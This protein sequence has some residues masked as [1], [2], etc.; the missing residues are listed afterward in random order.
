MTGT[1]IFILFLLNILLVFAV[2]LLYMRQNRLVE[3]EQRQQQLLEESEHA[4]A[5]LLEEIKDE[6]ENLIRR[7]Y[8][9]ND[10]L[11]STEQQGDERKSETGSV[12]EPEAE[13][14]P[15]QPPENIE[16]PFVEVVLSGDKEKP[17][18]IPLRDQVE[19]LAKEG[20]SIS[21]IAKK[22]RKGKTEIELLM[23]LQ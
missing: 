16:T 12:V 22:L 21:E 7:L 18:E 20:W 8:G 17:E 11:A 15:L 2:V 5:A 19:M 4:M 6:N 1:L 14:S 10:H 9:L 23:K 3:M 13:E